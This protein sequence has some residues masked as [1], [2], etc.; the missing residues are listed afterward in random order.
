MSFGLTD[1]FASFMRHMNPSSWSIFDKFVVEP[2][3]DILIFPIYEEVHIGRLALVLE[4]FENHL[5]VIAKQVFWMLEV[6]LSGS[7]AFVE[8]CRHEFEQSFL[9][10][11]GIDSSQSCMCG[12]LLRW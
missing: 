10:S 1:T 3:D 2:L 4:T 9:C 7:R 5:C 11:S 8:R 12:E 6:T